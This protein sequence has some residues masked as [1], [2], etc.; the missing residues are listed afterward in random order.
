MINF[1]RQF[2]KSK[3]VEPSTDFGRFMQNANSR[4]RKKVL[5]KAVKRANAD[6][7]KILE[8]WKELSSKES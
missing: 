2:G 3:K 8:D 1:L 6:Q 4:D 5:L 7:R